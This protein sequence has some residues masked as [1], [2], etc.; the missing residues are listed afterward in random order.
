MVDKNKSMGESDI[1]GGGGGGGVTCAFE[2]AGQ[3]MA[4]PIIVED[5]SQQG[6]MLIEVRLL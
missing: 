6:Q 4:C 5:M 1:K 2:V 3:K